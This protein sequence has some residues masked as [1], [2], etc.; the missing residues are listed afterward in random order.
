MKNKKFIVLVGVIIAAIFFFGRSRFWHTENNPEYTKLNQQEVIDYS[1]H[2]LRKRPYSKGVYFETKDLFLV[3]GIT[4]H[5]LPTA[6]NFIDEFYQRLV[7]GRPEIKRFLIVGPDHFEGC[8]RLASVTDKDFLT[9]YGIVI[10]NDELTEMLKKE[11]AV[12]DNQCFINEHSIGV[13]MTFIKKYFPNSEVSVL[14]FSSAAGAQSIDTLNSLVVKNFEDVFVI[15]SIDFSHY[16][17]LSVANEIDLKTQKQIE[18]LDTNNLTLS[19]LD[20]P[21]SLRFV[22]GFA[23]KL[24]ARPSF[25]S[26]ANSFEFTGIPDNTTGYFNVIFSR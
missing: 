3:A 20:S 12:T 6:E 2:T 17:T 1:A 10:N 22:S 19:Q 21:A 18:S 15:G 23:K 9:P 8:H 26:H 24:N 5:H 4:S 7:L 16:Q 13:Q 14:I 25:L 11:G